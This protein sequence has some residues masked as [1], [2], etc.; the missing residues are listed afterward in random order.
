MSYRARS[1]DLGGPTDAGFLYTVRARQIRDLCLTRPLPSR[2]R[3]PATGITID[4]QEKKTKQTKF[5]A[6]CV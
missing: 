4:G 5:L 1:A 6:S 3:N 2:G